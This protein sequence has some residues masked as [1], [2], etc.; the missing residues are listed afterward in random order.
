MQTWTHS[1][2]PK[3]TRDRDRVRADIDRWGY[4]LLE[5]A[6]EDP[7]LSRARER[8]TEQAEAELQHGHAVEGGGPTPP[9]GL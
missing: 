3:P 8:I 9:W 7:L 6:L 1:E 4:G 5:G 2:L